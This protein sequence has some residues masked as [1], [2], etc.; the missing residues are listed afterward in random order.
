M[1]YENRKLTLITSQSKGEIKTLYTMKPGTSTK[2]AYTLIAST[3]QIAVLMCFNER[4][5]ISEEELAAQLGMESKQLTPHLDILV[6]ATVLKLSDK[7]Y[8]INQKFQN[9]KVKV[10]IDLPIKRDTKTEHDDI[11]KLLDE[12]RAYIIDATVVRIM[13]TRKVMT[14][15]ALTSEIISQLS[16]KFTPD[17]KMIKKQIATLIDKE[18]MRRSDTK[19]D[20]YHYVA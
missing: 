2:Q 11:K 3:V 5:N 17:I 12:N 18:Y 20:E 19:T 13:K 1:V 6:K 8:S 14:H 7:I 4:D 10:K 16:G 9:K 15:S